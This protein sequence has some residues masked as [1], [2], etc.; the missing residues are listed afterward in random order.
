MFGKII[1]TKDEAYPVKRVIPKHHIKKPKMKLLKECFNCD[2]VLK[3]KVDYYF[4]DHIKSIKFKEI[5]EK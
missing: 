5:D 4:C 2:T 1:Y 3:T